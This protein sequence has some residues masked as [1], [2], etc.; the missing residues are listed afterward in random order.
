MNEDG[1]TN[2]KIAR[3]LKINHKTVARYLY[4]NDRK[5]NGTTR[6]TFR[7]ISGEEAVCN[8][9]N[10][11]LPLENYQ[12]NKRAD[13]SSYRFGY[14][15]QCRIRQNNKNLNSDPKKI[16]KDIYRRL[17]VRCK[18]QNISI[19]IDFDYLL[20]LFDKQSMK[21]F[22]SN[23]N[24]ELIRG[25][26]YNAHSL[27]I[28]KVIPE[29][30]YIRGNIVLCTKRYNTVKNNL[31]LEEIKEHMPTWYIKLINTDWLFLD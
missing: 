9:C 11:T 26:G 4:E 23:I 5:P 31:S 12:M 29:R 15:Y 24:M 20:D 6:K 18:K 2:R 14:C 27:T 1:Y 3:T 19:N 30:G 16:L 7:Q 21:C 25:G 13:G 28:D 22:Y 10:L 8:K 17:V